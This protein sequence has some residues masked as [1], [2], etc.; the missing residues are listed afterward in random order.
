M[1]NGEVQFSH[2]CH[3][4]ALQEVED[5]WMRGGRRNEGGGDDVGGIRGGGKGEVEAVKEEW[6]TRE[7]EEQKGGSG[8]GE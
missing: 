8:G 6:G 1:T 2:P 4:C 7:A 3:V 5:I